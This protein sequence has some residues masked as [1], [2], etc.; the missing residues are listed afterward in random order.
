MQFERIPPEPVRLSAGLLR[1]DGRLLLC[2][3][4]PGRSNFPNVWDLPGGHVDLGESLADA[5]VR[6]LDEE[7]GIRID[8]PEG[9]PWTTLRDTTFDLHV[10]L[11]DQ[12][13]GEPQNVALDE[14]D[15][16]RWFD[17]GE[18]AELE[19]AESSYL[20]LLQRAASATG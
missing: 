17:P 7:L 1:R 19:F 6:E 5:L 12:W 4:H 2:H 20:P 15:E 11:V 14:H 18:L 3:R 13:Q 16:I 8:P 10:F 9:L